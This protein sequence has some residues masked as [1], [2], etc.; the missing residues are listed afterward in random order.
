MFEH[1]AVLQDN[2]KPIVL[3]CDGHA[4]QASRKMAAYLRERLPGSVIYVLRGG[5][6][7]WGADVD[8]LQMDGREEAD[9]VQKPVR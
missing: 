8:R 2:K 4:C 5:W 6:E 7:A 9:A 3:Y 1:F